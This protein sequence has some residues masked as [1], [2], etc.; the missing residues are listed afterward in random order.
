MSITVEPDWW[1]DLFDDVYLLTDARSVCSSEQTAREVDLL[2][3]I[4]PLERD[5]RILDLCGGHGRHS[6]ELG[7]RGHRDCTVFDYSHHLIEK[8]RGDAERE[9]LPVR[10]VRGNASATGLEKESYDHVLILG[11]SLGYQVREDGDRSIAGEA[12]R[13]LRGGGWLLVDAVD[14]DIVR[15]RFTPNAWHEIGG[16]IVVCRERE[17]DGAVIRAR[18]VVLSRTKGLLRENRYAIRAYR[19]DELETLFTEAGF[20]DVAVSRGPEAEGRGD[21]GFMNHRIILTARKGVP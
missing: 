9:N 20:S 17:L 2:Q 21:L 10:F 8:G 14:G 11:N 3:E 19:P 1:K 6:L 16:D 7:R 13:L 18:E 15:E 12:H 5:D 4:L